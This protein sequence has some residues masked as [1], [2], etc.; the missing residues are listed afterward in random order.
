MT[1][2]VHFPLYALID[3]RNDAYPYNRRRL[4]GAFQDERR[5]LDALFV[6][7]M[8]FVVRVNQF[9]RFGSPFRVELYQDLAAVVTETPTASWDHTNIT[10]HALESRQF[11]AEEHR[12]LRDRILRFKLH[13][14]AHFA[15]GMS[16]YPQECPMRA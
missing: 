3:E 7:H 15:R 16:R 1:T 8:S 9:G 2:T 12:A 5:A 6:I 13:S 10:V 11:E 14:D 4:I